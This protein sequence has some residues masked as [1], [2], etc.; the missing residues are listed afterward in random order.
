MSRLAKTAFF[1]LL[2]CYGFPSEGSEKSE[3]LVIG[4]N[5]IDRVFY[6][7]GSY[8]K[9]GKRIASEMRVFQGGQAA[10]VAF[11]LSSLIED[12]ITYIGIFGNDS[13]A[14]KSRSTL[15]E[16]GVR[17]DSVTMSCYSN[18]ASVIVEKSTGE[19][20]ITFYPSIALH[21]VESNEYIEFIRIQSDRDLSQVKFIY[22]DCRLVELSEAIFKKSK[23]RSIPIILDLEIVNDKTLKLIPY[24]NTLITNGSVIQDLAGKPDLEL[25]LKAVAKKYNLNRLV[26]TLGSKGFMSIERTG[27][28]GRY[29]LRAQESFPTDVID[30]TGAGDAF[31]AAFIAALTKNTSFF[32]ALTFANFVASQKCRV[33]GPRLTSEWLEKS[34]RRLDESKLDRNKLETSSLRHSE[35]PEELCPLGECEKNLPSWHDPAL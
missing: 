22:S 27:Q 12:Q 17:V 23:I 10:N 5:A 6:V 21:L 19:R 3:I 8:D 32:D 28:D 4:N 35:V 30:T 1:L 18:N 20:Y 9:N 31:H 34:K 29:K 25:A 14:D 16:A 15:Q 24:A 7:N 13:D 11:T 33:L 2:V 26:A